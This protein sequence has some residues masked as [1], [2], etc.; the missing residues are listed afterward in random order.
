MAELHRG[1]LPLMIT[2]V[3]MPGFGGPILAERLAA[4]RPETKVLYTSGYAADEIVHMRA[5]G[6]DYA[7]LE[8]PFTRNDLVRRV[9]DLLDS[10]TV[11]RS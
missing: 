8:K 1:P 11:S 7:F 6:Q 5:P 9:R 2:D 3:V 10:P 4:I